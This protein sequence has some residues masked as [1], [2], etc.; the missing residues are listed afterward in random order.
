MLAGVAIAVAGSLTVVAFPAVV[1][2]ATVL[3]L[4][5]GVAAL[6]YVVAALRFVAV[7]RFLRLPSQLSMFAGSFLFAPAVIALAAGG[8]PGVR[9]WQLEL[10]LLASAALP[11]SGFIIE[12]R[13]RPGLRTMVFGL[14]LP[15]ALAEMRRGYPREMVML[16]ERIGA[17]DGPLLGHVD[18]VADLSTRIAVRL[19]FDA[20]AVR[21]VMLASQLHDVGKLFV[22]RAILDKPGKLDADEWRIVRGHA[23]EGAK[24]IA[25]VPE[26]ATAA[27]AVGEHHE[28]WAGGGYPSGARGE[29]TTPAARIIAAADVFDALTRARAYKDAWPVSDALAELER[30]K[31]GDFEPRVVDALRALVLDAEPDHQAA[32]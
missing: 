26:L 22:P 3:R 13:A 28:R 14:F 9:P 10:M 19:G 12:Q 8:A 2:N 17:Y 6:G 5:A 4:L 18:R 21:E 20:A 24:M 15:G 31:G 7:W 23:L 16:V 29:A 27:R 11:V 25:R 30:G 1:P 32:A